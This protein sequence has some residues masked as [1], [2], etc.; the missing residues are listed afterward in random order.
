MPG[1]QSLPHVASFQPRA[2]PSLTE[3]LCHPVSL[4]ASVAQGVS[5]QGLPRLAKGSLEP[6]RMKQRQDWHRTCGRESAAIESS[7]ERSRDGP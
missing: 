4:S 5:C 3:L 7:A 6:N 1:M 2:E